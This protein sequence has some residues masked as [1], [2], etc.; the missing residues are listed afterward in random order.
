MIGNI[1]KGD[2]ILYYSNNNIW[3]L[4][5]NLVA[6][7]YTHVGIYIGDD[8]LVDSNLITGVKVR[9]FNYNYKYDILRPTPYF[10]DLICLNYDK[11]LGNRYDLFGAIMYGIYK[12]I[13]KLDFDYIKRIK[14]HDKN[15]HCFE[16]V[17]SII[18]DIDKEFMIDYD[19]EFFNDEIIMS[20]NKADFIKC[21]QL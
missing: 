21:Q 4:A 10:A 13:F 12:T 3:D 15:Y 19:P 7:K 2:I 6:K 9:D 11:Y 5:I 18:K 16:L 1:K 17:G 14:Q 8:K 20:W